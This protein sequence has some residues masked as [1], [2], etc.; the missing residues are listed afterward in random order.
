VG[1]GIRFGVLC[2]QNCESA[3]SSCTTP[4]LQWW[5]TSSS[6]IFRGRTDQ[7]LRYNAQRPPTCKTSFQ[8]QQELQFK[9]LNAEAIPLHLEDTKI[10]RIYSLR[11]KADR[12][13]SNVSHSFITHASPISCLLSSSEATATPA[14]RLNLGIR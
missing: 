8:P 3:P 10:F 13:A 2:D 14:L 1:H 7:G 5:H 4:R 6:W 12:N 9:A 11:V